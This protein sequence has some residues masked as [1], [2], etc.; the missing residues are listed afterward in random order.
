[1]RVDFP[2][3][4]IFSSKCLGFAKCRWNGDIIPDKFIAELKPYVNY[5]TTCPEFEIGLGIPRDPIRIVFQD[6]LYRLMQLNTERDITKKMNDFVSGYVTSIKDIDGF[7]LKDR[8]P[9]CGLKDVK[10]YSSLKPSSSIKRT[11]G[12]FAAGVL[13]SFPNIAVETEA[14]LT[15]FMI[16]ENFLTKVFTYAK[17]RKIKNNPLMKNLVQ[18]HAENKFLLMAYCKKYLKVLGNIVANRDKKSLK[19]VFVEYEVNLLKAMEKAPKFTATINVLLHALGYFSKKLTSDEKRFFLNTLEE[20]RREQI[21]LSVPVNLV[22]SYII[23]FD[24]SYL[25]QQTFFEP[26]PKEL[27]EAKDSGKKR[28]YR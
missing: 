18:F 22:R 4:N 8:S 11:S 10:V 20:Y 17:F 25:K 5:V 13:K 19:E 7:I 12:F 1:M 27:I 24:E 9:S 3:P 15:N 16:R 26:Y 2:K 23:R 6:E 28:D 21:P 14:R